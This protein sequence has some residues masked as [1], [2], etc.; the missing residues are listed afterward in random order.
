MAPDE[1]F[2]SLPFLV[3]FSVVFSPVEID[4]P[5]EMPQGRIR[6]AQSCKAAPTGKEDI[7]DRDAVWQDRRERRSRCEPRPCGRRVPQPKGQGKARSPAG[8]HQGVL[9]IALLQQVPRR[10][11][12]SGEA[13]KE[14]WESLERCWEEFDA[15]K[16]SD[17]ANTMYSTPKD[18]L[19]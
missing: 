12:V 3:K 2:F 17:D 4:F 1:F 6:A 13:V 5:D 11:E 16:Y 19:R 8:A 9:R 7:R 10:A 14:A 18:V 15:L